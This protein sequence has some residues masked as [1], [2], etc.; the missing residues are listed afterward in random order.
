MP[1]Q[2]KDK[3][4]DYL[5]EREE[6][7]VNAYIDKLKEEYGYR[8]CTCIGRASNGEAFYQMVGE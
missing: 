7:D 4:K 8:E 6:H 1:E 2:A 3:I 5:A